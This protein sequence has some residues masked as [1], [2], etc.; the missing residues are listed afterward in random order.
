MAGE[1]RRP[2]TSWVN[3]T[4]ISSYGCLWRSLTHRKQRNFQSGAQYLSLKWLLYV[5]SHCNCTKYRKVW[6]WNLGQSVSHHLENNAPQVPLQTLSSD[7]LFDYPDVLHR[8][9]VDSAQGG[10]SPYYHLA[11]LLWW[12]LLVVGLWLFNYSF[13]KSKDSSK[14]LFNRSSHSDKWQGTSGWSS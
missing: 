3:L 8:G 1:G 13:A 6:K 5:S 11:P 10:G 2:K 7:S 12:C 4:C 9:G 14:A